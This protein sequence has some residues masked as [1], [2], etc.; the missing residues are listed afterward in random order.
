[1]YTIFFS[2]VDLFTG[3]SSWKLLRFFIFFNSGNLYKVTFS[4]EPLS[5]LALSVPFVL[6]ADFST[7]FLFR[8]PISI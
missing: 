6:S 4:A 5:P 8:V 2:P 7:S 3:D 1:M